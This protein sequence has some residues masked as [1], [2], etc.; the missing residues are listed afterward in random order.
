M[1]SQASAQ[2]MLSTAYFAL[3]QIQYA[4]PMDLTS[5]KQPFV[6][7]MNTKAAIDRHDAVRTS[8]AARNHMESFL[9]VVVATSIPYR[10]KY[11]ERR[12]AQRENIYVENLDRTVGRHFRASDF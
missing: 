6:P 2:A 4:K 12:R 10:A 8:F 9:W 3:F 7:S 5:A 1:L 11:A